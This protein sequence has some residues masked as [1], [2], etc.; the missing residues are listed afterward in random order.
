LYYNQFRF[1][2]CKT[3]QYISADPIGLLSGVNPYEYVHN[4]LGWIDPLGLTKKYKSK[5]PYHGPKPEYDHA[6]H[7]EPSSPDFRGGGSKTT[8]LPPEAEEV[9]RKLVPADSSGKNGL[10]KIVKEF[11]RYQ[12][13][14]G[15]VY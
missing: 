4:P 15:K 12:R 8:P 9:Y 7:H 3:G 13:N 10:D 2:D 14:N 11:Y 6:T 1:Y 5:S